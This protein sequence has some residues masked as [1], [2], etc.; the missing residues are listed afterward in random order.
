VKIDLPDEYIPLVVTA[1]DHY[2]AY[3]VAARREDAKYRAASDFF[4]QV[5][6]RG[7]GRETSAEG[8]KKKKSG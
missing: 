6:R 5:E 4:R 3:T 2:F 8:A 7:P 1:L